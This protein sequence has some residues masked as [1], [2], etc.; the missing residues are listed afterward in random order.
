MHK[1]TRYIFLSGSLLF[2]LIGLSFENPRVLLIST[3]IIFSHNIIYSFKN[4]YDKAIFFSFNVTFFIFLLGRMVVNEFFGYKSG[5]LGIF[6]LAFNDV[7]L[8]N[9][10]IICLFLSLWAIF[11]GYTLIQKVNLSFLKKKKELN[12][13]FVYSLRAFSLLFFY[14]C[15]IFRLYYVYE[16]QQTAM[17][18]GYYESFMTF[19]SSMPSLLV[20][21]SNMYDVA[22]LAY[23][24]TNPTKRKSLFPILLYIGEGLFAALAGRRSIFMLNLLIVFIYYCVRTARATK[25][26]DEKKWLD[27]SELSFGVIALPVLMGFLTFIG[28]L[29]SSFKGSNV[30]LNNPILEFFYS[31]GISANL[32]GY[33]K[34]YEDLLPK[35][36]LYTF[37]PI[38]EFVN[39]KIIRP[40]NG[41][42]EYFGQNIERAIN[43][44][45][46]SHALPYLIM[47]SAYL[48]GH[49]YGSSYI[50]EMFHDFSF[51]GVFIGSIVYGAIIYVFYYMLQNSNYIIVIF[52]L[53]MTRSI[54]FAPRGA[55]L[56]FI[57]SAFSMSK[58]AAVIFIVV[59]STILYSIIGQKSFFR[60]RLTLR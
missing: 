34:V 45:L 15:M 7:R 38:M 20:T 14:F 40:L 41:L 33:T 29:R 1:I 10:T 23:L 21:I 17:T 30:S 2:F 26:Q 6:G 25:R 56:S 60:P 37:G 28:K 47:P 50:A 36:I 5:L 46:F 18:E 27:K 59:G 19:A 52:T 42:P 53:M 57:V 32:I 48:M 54:L 39:N 43:G 8:V 11:M 51:L 55:A 3:L 58:I 35:G 9:L 31:Q 49:G 44:H 24:A 4:F 16:M 12:P 22:F 13:G